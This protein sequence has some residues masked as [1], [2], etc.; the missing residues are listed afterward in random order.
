MNSILSTPTT[1]AAARI[2]PS[3][4]FAAK[5]VCAGASAGVAGPLEL[6]PESAPEEGV[7]DA[8]EEEPG[9]V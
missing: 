6:A 7:E 2:A 1:P 9:M 8:E 5:P 3:T 4:S